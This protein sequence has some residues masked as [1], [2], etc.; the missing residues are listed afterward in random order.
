MRLNTTEDSFWSDSFFAR[1]VGFA[2]MYVRSSALLRNEEL[3]AQTKKEDKRARKAEREIRREKERGKKA[4]PP[5]EAARCS[6]KTLDGCANEAPA[7]ML[8]KRVSPE[9]GKRRD[10][11]REEGEQMRKKSYVEKFQVF[12]ARLYLTSPRTLVPHTIL[13]F[14]RV[15]SSPFPVVAAGRWRGGAMPSTSRLPSCCTARQ[16]ARPQRP[17]QRKEQQAQHLEL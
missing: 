16:P 15:P 2:P 12:L 8:H 10:K 9:G 17:W 6:C 13:L 11:H 4:A 5:P 1:L 3:N 14:R 7:P